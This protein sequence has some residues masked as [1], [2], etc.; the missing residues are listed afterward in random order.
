MEKV[1]NLFFIK[2][3]PY[4]TIDE[5]VKVG[6]TAIITVNNMFPTLVECQNDEQ[7]NLF[8]NPITKSTK[9]HKVIKKSNDINLSSDIIE[10]YKDSNES[11][12]VKIENEDIIIIN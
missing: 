2:N 12:L 10:K 6:D 8:Q 5:N 7:I 4:L 9:R 3:E 11:I 1:Y